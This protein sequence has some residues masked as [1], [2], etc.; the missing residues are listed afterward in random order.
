LLHKQSNES[1]LIALGSLLTLS[2]LLKVGNIV[3]R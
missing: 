1:A 3:Q 2:P